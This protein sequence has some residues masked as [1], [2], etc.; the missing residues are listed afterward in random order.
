MESDGSAQ[1]GSDFASTGID[2]PFIPGAETAVARIYISNDA[3]PEE[4][5]RFSLRISLPGQGVL[6]EP[7]IMTVTITDSDSK[8]RKHRNDTSLFQIYEYTILSM[9]I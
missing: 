3:Q 5:E 2:V 9:G 6:M 7:N 4:T 1:E 8:Y